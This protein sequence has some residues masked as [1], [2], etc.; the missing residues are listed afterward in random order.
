MTHKIMTRHS[1]ILLSIFILLVSCN[2]NNQTTKTTKNADTIY[3]KI[4]VDCFKEWDN[5][6]IFDTTFFGDISFK[7]TTHCLD[8]ICFVDTI[9]SEA[10]TFLIRSFH[11][12]NFLIKSSLFNKPI[13]VDKNSFK[14]SLAADLIGNGFLSPPQ[15]LKFNL[16]DSS[17]TF[18][19]F[20][21]HADTDVGD[22]YVM[23]VDKD[24]KTKVIAVEA[25]DMDDND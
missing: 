16:S 13:V 5:Q 21:A 23:H 12:I 10:D 4:N 3:Q 18:K 15:L 2:R 19:T 1:L 25:S 7:L 9:N 20:I 17:F 14:D 6:L 22:V 24:G 8:K 11:D